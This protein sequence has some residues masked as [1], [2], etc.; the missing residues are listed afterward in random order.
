MIILTLAPDFA[1]DIKLRIVIQAG[2]AAVREHK[3]DKFDN[4]AQAKRDCQVL[5]PCREIRHL[6]A[7]EWSRQANRISSRCAQI[8]FPR[9]WPSRRHCRNALGFRRQA[10]VPRIEAAFPALT[11]EPVVVTTGFRR[12]DDPEQMFSYWA[13]GI[14]APHVPILSPPF[15]VI[16]TTDGRGRTCG[17]KFCHDVARSSK[18][19]DRS[20]QA[21]LFLPPLKFRRCRMR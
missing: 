5:N 7:G 14:R 6:C 13:L 1:D 17:S 16:A 15:L 20:G 9:C 10:R 21:Y 11:S 12:E 4:S 8:F 2:V 3:C 19:D 18:V